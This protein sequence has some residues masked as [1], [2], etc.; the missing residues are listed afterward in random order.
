MRALDNPTDSM[1]TVAPVMD[2]RQYLKHFM[3]VLSGNS[4]AQAANLLS[5]PFLARIYSPHEFGGFALFV[6]ASAI[7]GAVACGRFDLAIPI[8]PPAGR[9]GMLWLCAMISAAVGLLSIAGAAL[10]WHF[11][12]QHAG[13]LLPFLFGLTVGLTGLCL[14]LSSFVMRHDLYQTQSLSVLARTGGA[15]IVQ[16]ALGLITPTSLSLIIG[17]TFGLVAQAILLVTVV[18]HSLNPKP[19]RVRDMRAMMLRFRRQVSVDIPNA[20]ISASSQNL[21]T[22]LVGAVYGQ[23]TVGFFSVGQRLTTVPLQ[24]FNDALGQVFFQ[25]AAASQRSFGSFWVETKFHLVMSCAISV[26]VLVAIWLLARP[27]I[28]FYLGARWEPAAAILVTLAP[29][30]AARSVA[31][32][33]LT[34]VFVLRKPHWLLIHNITVVALTAAAFAFALV[35]SLAVI[36][37]LWLASILL[38]VEYAAFTALLVY[39]VKARHLDRPAVAGLPR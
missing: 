24:L 19:P 25:K 16:I 32:S 38:A 29:M 28:V 37:F 12:G 13:L 6:A 8:A 2:R 11:I 18:W 20:L 22:F 3:I 26:A 33:L 5:Y 27:F 15:V 9:F 23:R 21:L 30:L 17:F 31:S 14:A 34:S 7:P 39:S 36:S 1:P 35:G 4:A 10:Y